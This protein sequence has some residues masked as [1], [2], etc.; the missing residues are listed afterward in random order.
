MGKIKNTF[1]LKFPSVIAALVMIISPAIAPVYSSILV[2]AESVSD[3]QNQSN[4]LQS[5]ID[6]NKANADNLAVQVD[7]LQNKIA[8]LDNQLASTQT[9]IDETEQKIKDLEAELIKTE[10][11]LERQK[12]ILRTN[13][14]ELY[15]TTGASSVELLF[16]SDN[17]STFVNKQQYLEQLK[18]SVKTSLDNVVA[19]KKDLE[20]KK[21]EQEQLKTSLQA[22]K[23]ALEATRKERA[24]LLA[25]TQG[26]EQ[27]YRAMV[28][29]LQ[30]QQKAI[31][32][33]IAALS[34]STSYVGDGSYP[35]AHVAEGYWT[36]WDCYG[37]DPWGMCYRQCVSY[38]AWKV[39][40]TGRYMPTT[41]VNGMGNA[42]NWVTSAQ[43]YGIP[44]DRNPTPGSVAIW[45]SGYY[46][47][48]MY[49]EDVYSD[50]TMLISQYNFNYDGRYS[51]MILPSSRWDLYFIHF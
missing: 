6:A 22:Q 19:L 7:S 38:T 51:T 40:S 43:S 50:G 33:K 26:E 20:A 14:K 27:K 13:L 46:G 24:D 28:E 39:A 25:Q 36:A 9:K 48:A 18:N 41:W 32:Q 49:V 1:K 44:V 35:W 37:N 23:D 42:R 29:E 47:H 11:E 31:N 4:S 16:S 30:N 2:G 34:R 21:A 5:Q 15:K 3:L 12:G 17:F 8:E 45:A 10:N